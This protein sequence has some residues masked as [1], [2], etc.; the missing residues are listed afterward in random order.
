MIND[1]FPKIL[2]T[3]SFLMMDE[4]RHCS[5]RIIRLFTHIHCLYLAFLKA[6]PKAQEDVEKKLKDFISDEQ[7][8]RKDVVGNLGALL[9][10]LLVSDESTVKELTPLYFSEQLDR[11]VLWIIKQVPEL[12]EEK[13]D[14][15][16]KKKNLI[17]IL[18]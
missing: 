17:Y 3:L 16:K 9:A 4:K 7:K 5:I 12:I 6:Y 11:Q 13:A 15:S 8:R 2:L 14:K 1:V 18:D 10:T